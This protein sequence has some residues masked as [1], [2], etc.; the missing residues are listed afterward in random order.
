MGIFLL[1]DQIH[2]MEWKK[3]KLKK[4]EDAYKLTTLHSKLIGKFNLKDPE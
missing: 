3:K 1:V 4:K 2:G